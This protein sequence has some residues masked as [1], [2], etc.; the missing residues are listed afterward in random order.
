MIEYGS[1]P[2]NDEIELTLFGPGY[3]EAIAVHLGAKVW[4][5]VDSCID[6][7]P[8]RPASLH[9]LQQIGMN[10]TEHVRAV[11]ASHWHD[12]HVRGIAQ[13][14]EACPSADFFLSAV[15]NEREAT[16]FLAGYGGSAAPSQVKGTRELFNVIKAREDV[17]PAMHRTLLMDPMIN[18]RQVKV[19]ALSP[20]AGAFRQFV[21]HIAQYLPAVRKPV[22]HAPD[23]RPNMAAI[24]LHID[25]GNDA[26]LLGA[27]LEDHKTLGWSAVIADSWSGAKRPSSAYKVAHHGSDTGDCTALWDTLLTQQPVSVLTPFMNGNVKLPSVSDRARVRSRSSDAYIS[28]DAS[29]KPRMPRPQQDR[30]KHICNNLAPV[31]PG[32]GA[33]RLRKKLGTTTWHAELFGSAG[34]L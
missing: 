30:L 17:V 32:F 8:K 33:V 10:A 24:A 26:I 22:N 14:A 9:Y 3:G 2:A 7:G 13:L 21:A 4:L 19:T 20:T 6:P 27:D 34:Q 25:L 1:P 15:L 23:I 31:N 18:G 29:R 5:L 12:D 16:D 11:V 28:S